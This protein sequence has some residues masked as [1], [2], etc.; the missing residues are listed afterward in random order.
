M[1]KDPPIWIAA[2]FECKQIPLDEPKRKE[3]CLRT[4][5]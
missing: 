2:D 5:R 4:N 3:N 1:N